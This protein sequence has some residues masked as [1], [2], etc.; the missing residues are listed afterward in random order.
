MGRRRHCRYMETYCI[1]AVL[2]AHDDMRTPRVFC[3]LHSRAF[4]T[5][6]GKNWR[7]GEHISL[8]FE[9]FGNMIPRLSATKLGGSEGAFLFALGEVGRSLLLRRRWAC[10]NEWWAYCQQ[11]L[12]VMLLLHFGRGLGGLCIYCLTVSDCTWSIFVVLAKRQRPWKRYHSRA[13]I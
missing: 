1:F 6:R 5:I 13:R 4:G 3:A 12:S 8:A 7:S 11:T 9:L 2:A 10:C